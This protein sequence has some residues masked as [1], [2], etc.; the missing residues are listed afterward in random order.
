MSADAVPLQEVIR[1][2]EGLIIGDPTRGLPNPGLGVTLGVRMFMGASLLESDFLQNKKVSVY[3]VRSVND[4]TTRNRDDSSMDDAIT[5]EFAFELPNDSTEDQRNA[6]DAAYIL[7]TQIRGATMQPTFTE[8]ANFS[9]YYTET[10]ER[11]ALSPHTDGYGSMQYL[12]IS[13]F[14]R[15][16]R[17]ES[18]TGGAEQ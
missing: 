6:R 3:R 12:V 17:L 2:I 1:V 14:Y 10:T 15:I 4:N 9:V 13:S 5:V 11:G 7:D 18:L 16:D 8:G